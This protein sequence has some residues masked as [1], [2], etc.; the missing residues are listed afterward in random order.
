MKFVDEATIKVAAGDGGNGCVSFRRE[1]YVP[2]GGPDGGDGGHGGSV[3]LVADE[4]L[5]TLADFRHARFYAAERG[6]NGQGRQMTGR[7]GEDVLV[8]VPIGTTVFDVET[9]E[10]IGD[11]TRN[12]ERLLVAE[13]GRGGLGN[14]HFKSSTNRAPRQSV[15]GTEG[16]RRGLRL[17]LR[18]LAD[19]GLLGLPNAG[20]STLLRA[21]SAARP[22]VAD[23]PFTTLHPGLGVVSVSEGRSFVMA[24]IPGLIEGAAE[25]AGLGVR[26]LKHL[27]RTRLLL[28]LVDTARLYEDADPAEDARS[29]VRELE[30]YSAEL[31]ARERWLVLNKADLFPADERERV[32]AD[33][34]A[35][36]GWDG[37]LHF[38][39]AETGEGTRALSQAVMNRLEA[40]AEQAREEAGHG[41]D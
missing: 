37:P 29:V 25:G 7:S 39:S 19:V 2:R 5:N 24:D 33:I 20:K 22:R 1:K 26:F 16:E 15:P 41:R 31:A 11:L 23:Y 27:A 35:R 8:A 40:M 38:I 34:R 18:V 4:G 36:L 12:G 13:G 3:W 32:A 30:R 6:A 21:V 14:I 10:R 9:G 28:H 17:E